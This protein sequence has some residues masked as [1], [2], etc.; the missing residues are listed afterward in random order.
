[1]QESIFP[2]EHD[3]NDSDNV[4]LLL[5]HCEPPQLGQYLDLMSL[6]IHARMVSL[7]NEIRNLSIKLLQPVIKDNGAD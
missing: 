3:I 5:I 2:P 7:M 6:G 1:M 4:P